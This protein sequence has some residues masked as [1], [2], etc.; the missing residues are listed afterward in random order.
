M[1][2]GSPEV[3]DSKASGA[4][5]AQAAAPSPSKERRKPG[6]GRGTV[7]AADASRVPARQSDRRPAPNK[8]RKASVE[9]SGS[10][11]SDYSYYSDSDSAHAK[12]APKDKRASK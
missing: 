5:S 4:S 11:G 1:W 8:K 12:D 2:Q 10:Y 6:R 9:S 3:H 7:R